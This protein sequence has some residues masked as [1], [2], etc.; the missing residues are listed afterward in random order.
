MSNTR[1]NKLH[2]SAHN[3]TNITDTPC[4]E[5][6]DRQYFEHN[7]VNFKHTVVIFAARCYAYARPI[8]SC[9]VRPSVRLPVCPSVTFLDH[10]KTNKHIFEIFSPSGSHAILFSMPKGTAIS[11][12]NR[13]NGGVNAGGVGK[14]AIL[15]LTLQQAR[16]CQHGRQ[17]TTATV[18]QVVTHRW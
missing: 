8:P 3:N 16:C 17:W 13:L 14:I 7:F 5:K 2:G 9:G 6:K 18:P 15:S 1:C 12:G 4:P 11:D 10:I